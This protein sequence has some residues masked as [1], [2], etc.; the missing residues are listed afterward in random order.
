VLRNVRALP[1]PI[2]FKGAQ[3]LFNVPDELIP[4]EYRQA[5]Q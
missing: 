4:A 3:G 2:P 1:T 5:R